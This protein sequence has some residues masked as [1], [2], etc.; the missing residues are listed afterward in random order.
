MFCMSVASLHNQDKMSLKCNGMTFNLIVV[1]LLTQ[2]PPKHLNVVLLMLAYYFLKRLN[3][4]K[5]FNKVGELFP[6]VKTAD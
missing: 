2:P 1:S 3:S 5:Q 4:L 6:P